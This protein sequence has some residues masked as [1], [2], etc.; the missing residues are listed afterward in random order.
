M[1]SYLILKEKAER[2]KADAEIQSL[3]AEINS[4]DHDMEAFAGGYNPEKASRLKSYAF[5]PVALASGGLLYER[6]DQ[7][8]NELLLGI[9]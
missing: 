9:R 4:G 3:L 1:R 2:F 6:L 7:L 5:D 8:T